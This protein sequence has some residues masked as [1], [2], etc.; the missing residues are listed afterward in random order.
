MR[1]DPDSDVA[2]ELDSL[3]EI[4]DIDDQDSLDEVMF[5]EDLEAERARY[6]RNTWR[7]RINKEAAKLFRL[8][9]EANGS[10]EHK[11]SR[12]AMLWISKESTKGIGDK[13]MRSR[14]ANFVD[15]CKKRSMKPLVSERK[16]ESNLLPKRVSLTTVE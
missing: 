5:D 6:F 8:S 1:E 16:Q 12:F 13:E 15:A 3:V 9:R 2:E 10:L 7:N 4:E 11:W 14:F